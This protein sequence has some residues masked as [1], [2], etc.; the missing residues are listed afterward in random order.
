MKV[1]FYKEENGTWLDTVIDCMTGRLGYSHCE[2]V[3]DK[4]DKLNPNINYSNA[5]CFGISGREGISRH[6]KINLLNG[7]WDLYEILPDKDEVQNDIQEYPVYVDCRNYLDLKYDY[8]GIMFDWVLP[9]GIQISNRWYCSELTHK[10]LFGKVIKVSPNGLSLHPR[11]KK[12]NIE[13]L[14]GIEMRDIGEM[15]ILGEMECS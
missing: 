4:S 1:A 10:L 13:N 14:Q 9:I 7:N 5:C 2:L 6:K 15:E 11:L 8:V 12:I 3:F